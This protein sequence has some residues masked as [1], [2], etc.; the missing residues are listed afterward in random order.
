VLQTVEGEEAAAGAVSRVLVMRVASFSPPGATYMDAWDGFLADA[1][2]CL[3]QQFDLVV[4]DVMQNGGG[5]V[6]L[7]LRLLELLVQEYS[8]DHTQVQ[9]RYDLPHSPLMD[10]YV[11]AVN[12]PDPYPD[13]EA[14]EQILD[15]ATQQSFPDGDAYYYPGRNVT[16]GGQV[17]WR[18]NWFA[19]DC[20]EAE[21]LP[22]GG[23]VPPAFMPP[24]RLVI[25]T[26]G[27]CGSTC[28]SFTKIPQEGRKATFVGAGGLWGEGMD[29]SAFAGGFVANPDYLWNLANW[30][31]LPFP[32]FLT[33]QR[34]QFGWAAW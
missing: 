19:L 23:W 9:M 33:D 32:K 29:V 15:P 22:S 14:V 16:Q 18:T 24:E 6:C 4:V 31:G 26:D 17:S 21:A 20:R 7:G 25:L 2:T 13:P 11:A 8:D 34:W 28:A 10:A 5:Y 30:S 3:S 12:A 1:Q 27:T